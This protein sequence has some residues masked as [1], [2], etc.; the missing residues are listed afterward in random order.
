MRKLP[1]PCRQHAAQQF[2]R[3]GAER[4]TKSTADKANAQHALAAQAAG[5]KARRQLTQ[6]MWFLAS[7]S[8]SNSSD[9]SG[10]NLLRSRELRARATNTESHANQSKPTNQTANLGR[11]TKERAPTS[12][13]RDSTNVTQQPTATRGKLHRPTSNTGIG[14]DDCLCHSLNVV[15]DRLELV[16]IDLDILVL[17]LLLGLLACRVAKRAGGG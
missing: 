3:F 9:L 2:V 5:E 16:Q 14:E 13:H 1:S 17:V 11:Y 8:F 12:Q 15:L 6:S 4:R 7:S 10:L